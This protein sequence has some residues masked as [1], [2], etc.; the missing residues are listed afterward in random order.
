M[1][2]SAKQLPI[3]DIERL[4]TITKLDDVVGI[5]AMVRPCPAAP[6]TMVV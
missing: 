6:M 5:H 4:S 2:Q 1:M 3:V